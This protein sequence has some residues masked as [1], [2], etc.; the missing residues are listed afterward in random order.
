[1]NM[2]DHTSSSSTTTIDIMLVS[3][4]NVGKTTLVRT[5]LG[6]DVGEVL[7]A[8][9][10]TNAVASYDL[11]VDENV[12]A[13]RLWDTP[14]FGDSFRLAKRLRQKYFWIAWIVREIWDRYRNPRLWLSQRVALDLRARASVILY[15]IN[16]LE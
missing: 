4:T 3:H 12:G 14:G 6:N 7:D 2:T 15:L 1:M 8:P 13:L 10:V 16:S 9:D 5:L 11:V